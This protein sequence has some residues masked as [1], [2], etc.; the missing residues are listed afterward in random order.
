MTREQIQSLTSRELRAI[1]NSTNPNGSRGQEARWARI[2]L[3][4]R[5]LATTNAARD[6]QS[7]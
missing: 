5:S 4:S 3:H 6:R 1:V 2:E 7:R